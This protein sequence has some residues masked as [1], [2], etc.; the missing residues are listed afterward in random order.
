MKEKK[1]IIKTRTNILPVVYF[2]NV[3][4][5]HLVK[6][7]T[8]FK[9]R[10]WNG[11]WIVWA[12]GHISALRWEPVSG[13]TLF[14]MTPSVRGHL[15]AAARWLR[16]QLW[17]TMRTFFLN[18]LNLILLRCLAVRCIIKLDH[19]FLSA[20]NFTF[21]VFVFSFSLPCIFSFSSFFPSF[22]LLFCHSFFVSFS[23][24]I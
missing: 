18:R 12:D 3:L 14:T 5:V 15:D 10:V 2:L 11:C 19:F 22:S 1:E 21:H 24:F 23:S 16:R 20:L 9:W 6:F 13:D 7:S 17:T 8:S 4:H